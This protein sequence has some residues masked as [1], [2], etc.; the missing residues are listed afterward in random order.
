[1]GLLKSIKRLGSNID[2]AVHAAGR[3]IDNTVGVQATSRHLGE[4]DDFVNQ[5]IPGGWGTVAAAATLGAGAAGL[6][7]A[8]GLFSGASGAAAETGLK[9]MLT[10]AGQNVAG[11]T[12]Q[13]MAKAALLLKSGY[14]ATKG[15]GGGS[16][17][18]NNASDVYNSSAETLLSKLMS[19]A[20]A[21]D[22]R[23]YGIAGDQYARQLSDMDA[24]IA[25]GN[26]QYQRDLIL[27][28]DLRNNANY[29]ADDYATAEGRAS[30]DVTMAFNKG[31][32]ANRI[33]LG[34]YGMN[35]NS[36]GFSAANRAFDANRAAAQAAAMTGTRQKMG[37]D[38]RLMRSD[39]IKTNMGIVNPTIALKAQRAGV[40]DQRLGLNNLGLN[41]KSVGMNYY[42]N[43]ASGLQQQAENA[44]QRTR[45][46]KADWLSAGA[47]ILANWK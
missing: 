41:S 2:D 32:E 46:N 42:T 12:L 14:E 21:I 35:P 40:S 29:T 38:S 11:M 6:G 10:S 25:A 7:P 24:A 9:A 13:Q 37:S 39:A 30:N 15:G 36:S 4:I 26:D 20:D 31:E 34:R 17:A 19:E 43:R 27:A 3:K 33:R 16:G 45:D 47:N 18:Y 8:S 5:K 28:N 44:L 1:M 22:Q 23:N